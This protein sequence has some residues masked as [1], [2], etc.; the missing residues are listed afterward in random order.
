MRFLHT[1]LSLLRQQAARIRHAHFDEA[2]QMYQQLSMKA[3]A[4]G[5]LSDGMLRSGGAAVVLLG[6]LVLIGW[7]AHWTA[8]LEMYSGT[9]AMKF[10]TA[11][12]FILCGVGAILLTT[13]FNRPAS[14]L[15]AL[16]TL[17]GLMSILEYLTGSNFG[18]D[19]YF[20]SDFIL[21]AAIAPGPASILVPGQMA[22]LT[23]SCFMFLGG[24]LLVAGVGVNRNWQL[25]LVGSLAFIVAVI[26]AVALFGYIT[27]IQ[28]AYGW[29]ASSRIATHTA[30]AFLL[31]SLTLL[32]WA[33]QAAR[34]Q[35]VN[36]MGWLPIVSAVTL[37]AVIASVSIASLTQLESAYEWRI[38][39]D[40]VLLGAQT[41]L[42]D[43]A[44]S[45]SG[46]R[47]YALTGEPGALESY[48]R[49]VV[50]APQQLSV[51]RVLTRDNPS[52][53]LR[54]D[55]LAGDSSAVLVNAKRL[56]NSRDSQEIKPLIRA[57]VEGR[58]LMDRAAADLQ[59]FTDAE[60]QLLAN[61]TATVQKTLSNTVHFLV[62]SSFLAAVLLISAHLLAAVEMRRR[63]RTEAKLLAVS[64]LQTAILNAANYAI[65]ATSVDGIVTSFNSTA[66]RW[67]GYVAA[68]IIG[69]K[70]LDAWHDAGEVRARA[71]VLSA[72][73]GYTVSA[74]F[75]T[76]TA[77]ARVAH[78]DENEWILIRKDGSRFPAWLSVTAVLDVLGN[79]V[80]YVRVIADISKRKKHDAELRLSEER[81][82]RAFDDAPIGMALI[83]LAGRWLRVNRAL[84]DMIGY[85]DAELVETD[86]QVVTHPD[87]LHTELALLRQVLAGELPSYQ[88]EKRY[89][90]KNGSLV[91][92]MLSV[93]LVR[94]ASGNPVYFVKQI[95]NI[96][97][98]REID[99]MK[100]EFI[101]T[102]SHE[103]RTPLTS[104][105]G[106]LGLI[107]AGVLGEL[108]EKAGALV[109]IAYQNCERLVRIIN[110][111]LDVEKIKSGGME[112]HIAN[113]PV[114]AFLQQALEVNQGFGLKYL[115]RFVLEAAPA[116]T[117]LLADSDR[118]MQVM[119]NL[120][121]NAAKFS[122]RGAD[123]KVRASERGAQVRI[124]VEDRGIGIPEEF[125]TRVFEKF[126]QADS[127][128]SRHFEGT[129]LGLSITRQLVEAM[130]GT[131]GFNTVTGQGTTFYFELPQAGQA[132]PL[133]LIP[134]PADTVRNLVPPFASHPPAA[135]LRTALPRILHV[136]DD[137]D[138]SSV[139]GTALAGKAEVV[140]ARTLQE[141]ER[142]LKET[143]FSVLV[144]DMGL[145]DGHGLI[146]LELPALAA[147]SMPV[148]ILSSTEVSRHVQ[149]RVA[150]TIVKSR[151]SEAHIVQTILSLLPKAPA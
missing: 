76:F 122:P 108:P 45:Q 23:A 19:E 28:A 35:D 34:K 150:A 83:G 55:K 15:G 39:T 18:V 114:A 32:G 131:I 112:L 38:H 71:A 130:G 143:S 21:G 87:D 6:I 140:T 89:F 47:N 43:L 113:V 24:A 48:R 142:L 146:L 96:T 125:R 132:P 49:A 134:T 135:P 126:A 31:L 70:A 138:L 66:E 64:T 4:G 137:S 145:P 100:G 46:M 151:V 99:R 141:A 10:N 73:L 60:H 109:K 147:R 27:G 120:L 79:T 72:E 36:F 104:I 22:P 68:D 16:V 117:V 52:Q 17:V 75:E 9:A 116:R 129:G 77:K 33:R 107:E 136:E 7:Y 26:A 94:D 56:L 144:M 123:V 148:V 37:M 44:E 67:L 139:I 29:G 63:R 5:P 84:C 98:R 54:L 59:G 133:P 88:M 118:L 62:L 42:G 127:S 86:F 58:I 93:S 82:R 119:A 81:F 80:G 13:R 103:L 121:S 41:L 65:I 110:D 3:V 91:F 12:C 57:S 106:S 78:R 11:L 92:V 53:L 90:H 40:D 111:I 102:V 14:A 51:L 101:S 8:L 124:E 25:M 128:T 105:R 1:T 30:A 149:Q 85:T 69:K 20:V 74:G 97:Q 2:T 115:V 61:R 50:D 95:E